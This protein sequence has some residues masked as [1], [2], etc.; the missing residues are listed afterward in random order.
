MIT[1]PPYLGA[2][3]YI[4]ASSLSLGW[5]DMA[6]RGELRRLERQTIGREHFPSY[7]VGTVTC[8]RIGEADDLLWEIQKQNPLRAHIAWTYLAE[9]ECALHSMHLILR[10]GGHLVLVTGPNRICGHEFDTPRF[11]EEIANRVGFATRFKLIDNIRSR[12]LMVKRNR[13]AAVIA[14]E[15]VL[16]LQKQ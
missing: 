9:M 1:S 3:K 16:C 7:E 11:L 13:T 2:Q 6:Y 10:Q 8:S 12:G 15:W 4:R 14:S 5:L